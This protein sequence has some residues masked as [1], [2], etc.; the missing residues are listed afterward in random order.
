MVYIFESV[1]RKEKWRKI[2]NPLIH[3]PDGSTARAEPGKIQEL[4]PV[5]GKD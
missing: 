4:F 2:F 5:G 3:Y 1:N